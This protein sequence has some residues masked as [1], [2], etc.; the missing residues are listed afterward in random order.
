MQGNAATTAPNNTRSV[1]TDRTFCQRAGKRRFRSENGGQNRGCKAVSAP[2]GNRP[3][4]NS[5]LGIADQPR[6]THAAADAARGLYHSPAR[7]FAPFGFARPA[8][9]FS[10]AKSP[11]PV[12]SPRASGRGTPAITTRLR[13]VEQGTGDLAKSL[14]DTFFLLASFCLNQRL[15]ARPESVQSFTCSQVHSFTA[16]SCLN[17][18]PLRSSARRAAPEKPRRR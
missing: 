10:L 7:R 4:V 3:C 17:R 15:T 11:R 16:S 18:E 13:R 6:R 8:A 5:K 12:I 14:C 9:L 2:C 1:P